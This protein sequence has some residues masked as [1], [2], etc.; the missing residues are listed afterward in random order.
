MKNA[1]L[2]S[3]K[4]AKNAR[5]K[6]QKRAK[7]V[8]RK[9]QKRAKNVNRPQP[10][11]YPLT[12]EDPFGGRETVYVN[13]KIHKSANRHWNRLKKRY[14][15]A[16]AAGALKTYKDA[17]G[18]IAVMK[19]PDEAE[20]KRNWMLGLLHGQTASDMSKFQAQQYFNVSE[21]VAH[22]ILF[23]QYEIAAPARPILFA[24]YD[25]KDDT[26]RKSSLIEYVKENGILSGTYWDDY[27]QVGER[28]S[29]GIGG[30]GF[31]NHTGIITLTWDYGA[32][33]EANV[34][35]LTAYLRRFPRR[36]IM[37]LFVEA[38]GVAGVTNYQETVSN[39]DSD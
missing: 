22:N 5:R 7:N 29:L 30:G 20:F 21:K 27:G 33:D 18:K 23:T 36:A 15:E 32:S 25:N 26:E 34:A 10:K 28:K 9:S 4:R 8:I 35:R 37:S 3:I 38:F 19:L 24:Q 6:S 12:I 16:E 17:Q 39:Y 14:D 11:R 2:R 13:Q 31:Q 1:R